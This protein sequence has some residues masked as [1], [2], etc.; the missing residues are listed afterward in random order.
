MSYNITD[1][2]KKEFDFSVDG[3]V[4][5]AAYPTMEQVEE[6]QEVVARQ[7]KAE[8]ANEEDVQKELADKAGDFIYDLIRPENEDQES[9]KTVMKR[10]NIVAIRNFNKMIAKEFGLE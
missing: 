2:V 7:K 4:Y 9:I 1:N 10:Q 3:A 6:L 8:E 5:W